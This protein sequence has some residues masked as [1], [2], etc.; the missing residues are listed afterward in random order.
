MNYETIKQMGMHARKIEMDETSCP[1]WWIVENEPE[2][3]KRCAWM[4]GYNS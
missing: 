3:W 2:Y 4:D 1:W